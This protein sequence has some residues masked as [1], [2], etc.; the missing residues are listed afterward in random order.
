MRLPMDPIRLCCHSLKAGLVMEVAEDPTSQPQ[1]QILNLQYGALPH[2]DQ[3]ASWWQAIQLDPPTVLST[4]LPLWPKVRLC[5]ESVQH[6]A[7]WVVWRGRCW[8]LLTALWT[9][10]LFQANGYLGELI[11]T[12]N[13]HSFWA[14]WTHFTLFEWENRG[15]GIPL[16]ASSLL[17]VQD[18]AKLTNVSRGYCWC[19]IDPKLT[20][21]MTLATYCRAS[22]L[23]KL[24]FPR[25]PVSLKPCNIANP[26]VLFLAWFFKFPLCTSADHVNWVY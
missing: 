21:K 26:L 9:L 15:P 4:S 11:L 16:G 7:Q 14:F 6:V 23:G 2:E 3:A 22:P 12:L 1:R 13:L 20:P 8:T 24:N 19:G 10:H 18:N 25:A 5:V 17:Q